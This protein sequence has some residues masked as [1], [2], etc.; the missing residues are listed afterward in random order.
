MTATAATKKSAA[1]IAA[2]EKRE[3]QRKQLMEMKRKNKMA[4]A[5]TAATTPD[6]LIEQSKLDTE[7]S[8]VLEQKQ[9]NGN[10]SAGE[11]VESCAADTI[12]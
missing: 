6:S 7:Q 3:A 11:N 2:T 9:R 12:R 1:A 5:E 10:G 8:Q 4:M